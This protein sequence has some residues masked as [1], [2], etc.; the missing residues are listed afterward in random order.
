MALVRIVE[1]E[2]KVIDHEGDNYLGGMDFDAAI[3]EHIVVPWLEKK[4]QFSNLLPQMKSESGKHDR[5][6][7]RL[8]HGAE[9]AKVELSARTVAEIA[10]TAEDDVGTTIDGF[11]SITRSEYEAIIKAA[12]DRTAEMLK[13]ILTKIP[14]RPEDLKFV[15]MVGGS[16]YTPFI[17][18]RIEE[19]MGIPVNTGI[20]PTNAIAIGPATL[21][22]HGRSASV[23]RRRLS[24]INRTRSVSR[25]PT[26]APCAKR[27]RCSQQE[28]MGQRTGRILSHYT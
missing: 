22:Q 7:L 18:K 6:W 4:G 10:I 8:L 24:P 5:L 1:G 2:L 17:R 27:R 28:W 14:R 20:N 23:M 11:I 12:V 25:S 16:T 9:D 19:L 13:T 21:L 3:V 15:L 26:I